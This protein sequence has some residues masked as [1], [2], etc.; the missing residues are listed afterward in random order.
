MPKKNL[1]FNEQEEKPRDG[2]TLSAA[3]ARSKESNFENRDFLDELRWLRQKA[4]QVFKMTLSI[5]TATNFWFSSRNG[6]ELLCGGKKTIIRR[7]THRHA[8]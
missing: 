3:E 5:L 6:G 2:K 1:S 7:V 4:I 8:S